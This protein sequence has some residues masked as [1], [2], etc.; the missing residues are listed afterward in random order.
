MGDNEP[1]TDDIKA[2]SA[3][4]SSAPAGGYVGDPTVQA[5]WDR[6]YAEQKQ[7]WSD[8]LHRKI[9]STPEWAHFNALLM[10]PASDRRVPLPVVNVKCNDGH[11]EFFR[12]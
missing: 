4:D 10:R 11:G 8:L 1:L 12:G 5:E 7:L 9:R 6:R 2:G 3:S